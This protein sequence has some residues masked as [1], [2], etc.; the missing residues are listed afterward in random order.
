MI[1]GEQTI[2]RTE[3]GCERAWCI[4]GGLCEVW[5]EETGRAE[6]FWPGC[7]CTLL[8][9]PK[10]LLSLVYLTSPFKVHFKFKLSLEALFDTLFG[11]K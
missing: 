8:F 10:M 3:R 7:L 2:L 11:Y 9:Q 6:L 1:E 5:E 4:Q